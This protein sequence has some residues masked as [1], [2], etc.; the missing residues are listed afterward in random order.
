MGMKNA[1]TANAEFSKMTAEKV[2]IGRVLQKTYMDVN[3]KGTEAAAVTAVAMVAAA[4]AA[5]EPPVDFRVD[6]PFIVALVDEPTNQILFLG[7]ITNP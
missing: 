3:E 1:F 2:C 4:A 7:T 6:R 5:P